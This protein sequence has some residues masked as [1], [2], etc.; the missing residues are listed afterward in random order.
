MRWVVVWWWMSRLIR[1]E[2]LV[3]VLSSLSSMGG[4][5]TKIGQDQLEC[6][7]N[8]TWISWFVN[9]GLLP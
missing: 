9:V 6:R 5:I 8:V 1:M 3:T 4:S 7:L 2:Q